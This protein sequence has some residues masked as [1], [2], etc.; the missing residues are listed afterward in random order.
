[1]HISQLPYSPGLDGLRALAVVAVMVYHANH[2]WLSGGFLGVEVFFV[3]S[4]YLI[5]LLLIAEHERHDTIDLGQFWL[6]RARRLLP[7]LFVMLAALAVYMTV[8]NSK[9]LGRTRGDFLGGLFYGSNWYQ[10]VVGQSYTDIEAFAPLRHLWSLAVEEQFYLVWPLVMIF[11]LRKGRDR[12]PQVAIRLFLIAFG[13]A[14]AVAVLYRP[15]FVASDCS[16]DSNGYLKVF[17]RCFNINDALYLSTFSRASGLLLGA[18]FAMLW[19]PVALMRGPMRKKGLVLDVIAL[20]GLILL[21]LLMWKITLQDSFTAEYDPWLYRGG[22]FFTGIVT[23]LVIAAV[24]H[25]R[26]FLGKLL[27]NP[28]FNWIGTRSYGLYLFHWPIYQIIRKSGFDMSVRQ[29]VLA[30]AITVPITEACYRLIET[31]IRRHG[32]MGWR[33]EGR[34]PAAAIYRRRRRLML[35]VAATSAVLGFA[36]MSV[37]VADNE[38]VGAVECSVENNNIA[39]PDST[40]STSSTS[41]TAAVAET[42]LTVA[43]P[44]ASTDA[45]PLDTT[46]STEAPIT[47]PDTTTVTMPASDKAPIA[48]G[49]SV[50]LGAITQLQEGGF[51][52]DALKSRQGTQMAELVESLRAMD[53]IGATVVIQIGTNGPVDQSTFDRIMAQLPADTTPQV[54]FLTVTAPRGWTDGNNAII[55]NLP[56]LYRNIQILDWQAATGMIELCKDGIHLVCGTGAQ[57]AYANL[58]FAAIGRPDLQK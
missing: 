27:G 49:E 3:I 18:G 57:R 12:L 25:R 41:T 15:G 54:I 46:P 50:M 19:R 35:V 26:A 7:A 5:T 14:V 37:A 48:L 23:L 28:A 56:T 10:I 32:L 30:M 4:G 51:Y 43:E 42:T 6:R 20:A 44:T 29:F 33:T 9:P 24:V 31:P 55:R 2:T 11:L 34:R 38:C 36:G 16:G 21:G 45:S 1:M 52:V 17:G 58:I 39:L 13:I 40:S 22:F 47:V 8:F 53:Q